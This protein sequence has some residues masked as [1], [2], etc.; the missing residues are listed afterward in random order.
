MNFDELISEAQHC[1]LCPRLAHRTKVL[2]HGNGNPTARLM[3]IAEAPGRL[4]AE[5]TGIPL[6]CD[7]TGKN[8]DKLLKASGLIR[9]NVFITNAVICNPLTIDGNNDKPTI[10]ELE[11]CSIILRKT[12]RCV[13]P[14]I[15]V[16]LGRV[17][18][19]SLKIIKYHEL[20]LK[21]DVGKMYSW[22]KCKLTPLYHP[23]PRVLVHRSFNQ[24][25]IDYRKIIKYLKSL[26]KR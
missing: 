25:V 14:R 23:S 21:I 18:L 24:Q 19:E 9:D 6:T 15:I 13:Q 20:V 11:N 4:G 10:S 5:K 12:I 26:E 17:A 3:F 2:S 1:Q 8:F 7:Q 16:T 22:Y